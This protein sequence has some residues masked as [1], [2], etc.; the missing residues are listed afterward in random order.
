MPAA[1]RAFVKDVLPY[2]KGDAAGLAPRGEYEVER[3]AECVGLCNCQDHN[4]FT[5]SFDAFL[6]YLQEGRIALAPERA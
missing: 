2:G 3:G 1:T 6:Q 5:L 4:A